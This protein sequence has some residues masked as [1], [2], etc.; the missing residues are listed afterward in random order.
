[1][2]GKKWN[3]KTWE[4]KKNEENPFPK[5]NRQ[6]EFFNGF[7]DENSKCPMVVWACGSALFNEIVVKLRIWIVHLLG[8][9]N[10]V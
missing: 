4:E 2:T 7:I 9:E 1:M 10:K 3:E 5:F 8:G 6:G